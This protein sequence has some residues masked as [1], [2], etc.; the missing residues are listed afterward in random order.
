LDASRLITSLDILP[1]KPVHSRTLALLLA[2]EDVEY[3][4]YFRPFPFDSLEIRKRIVTAR[5]DRYWGIFCGK[6]LTGFFML[7]GMD[8]GYE[9]PSYGVYISQ[10]WSGKG[11]SKLSL[12]FSMSW[13][14]LNGFNTLML[15]VHPMNTVAK[16]IY[17]NFGFKTV[18]C[19]PRNDNLIM[20]RNLEESRR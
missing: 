7:R 3:T 18:G 11:L 5:N 20:H 16:K 9:I 8:D 4:K 1:L 14:K 15:K 10:E 13:C 2:R 12:L 19:D 17:E 6:N